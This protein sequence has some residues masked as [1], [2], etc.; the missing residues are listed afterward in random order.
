MVPW[1]SFEAGV[2]G[3]GRISGLGLREVTATFLLRE[4]NGCPKYCAA[5]ESC[6]KGNALHSWVLLPRGAGV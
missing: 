1:G 3:S 6:A 2:G 4:L 5:V